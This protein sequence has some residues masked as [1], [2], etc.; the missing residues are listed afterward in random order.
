[1]TVM[2]NGTVEERVK[3]VIC[4]QLKVNFSMITTDASFVHDL[5]SDSLSQVEL[6]RSLEKEFKIEITDDDVREL[7]TV[8]GVIEFISNQTMQERS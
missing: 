3:E 8:A 5:G 6:L 4:R 7:D 2:V 1:M